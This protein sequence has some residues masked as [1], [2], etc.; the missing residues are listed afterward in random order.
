MHLFKKSLSILLAVT[1]ALGA[2][3]AMPVFAAATTAVSYIERYWDE[4]RHVVVDVNRICSEYTELREVQGNRLSAGWYTV[5]ENTAIPS[6]L[7][8]DTGA[9]HLIVCDGITLTLGEGIEVGKNASLS[10]YTQLN[11]SGTIRTDINR[12]NLPDAYKDAAL[13]AA[14]PTMPIAVISPFTAV[15]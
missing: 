12:N 3:T 5:S 4:T 11:N 14:E 7:M 9:V 2:F 10:I 8:I 15:F 1:I 6:R 13:S